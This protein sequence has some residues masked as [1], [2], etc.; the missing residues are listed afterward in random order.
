RLENDDPASAFASEAADGAAVLRLRLG[1]QAQ[2]VGAGAELV[3]SEHEAHFGGGAA[4][5]ARHTLKIL[6]VRRNLRDAARHRR[7]R[8]PQRILEL[9]VV[10]PEGHNRG[11]MLT[12]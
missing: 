7:G 10:A 9:L 2:V 3:V 4:L 11:V 12:G 6:I 8:E 1:V 5:G